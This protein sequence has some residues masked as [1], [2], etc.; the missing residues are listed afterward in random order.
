MSRPE[1]IYNPIMAMGFSAPHC[2]NGSCKYVRALDIYKKLKSTKKQKTYIQGPQS[3]QQFA[4]RLRV[5]EKY[6]IFCAHCLDLPLTIDGY[7]IWLM[8]LSGSFAKSL[9][10]ALWTMKVMRA[11]T[12]LTM[13]KMTEDAN[14]DWL[15]YIWRSPLAQERSSWRKKVWF[16]MFTCILISLN[17]SELGLKCSTLSVKR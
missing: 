14:P 1:R 12:L 15:S 5:F 13:V 11:M 9:Y 17:C 4:N 6:D 3:E 2:R 16:D 8:D 10:T 7:M